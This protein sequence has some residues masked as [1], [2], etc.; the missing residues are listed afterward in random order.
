MIAYIAVH[1]AIDY[2]LILG[3]FDTIEKA[4]DA[5]KEVMNS[6]ETDYYKVKI[7]KFDTNRPPRLDTNFL[8]NNNEEQVEVELYWDYQSQSV[9][10]C[11]ME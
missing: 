4:I 6:D 10:I 1:S 3:V 9:I 2:R 8:A 7:L 11:E 5:G